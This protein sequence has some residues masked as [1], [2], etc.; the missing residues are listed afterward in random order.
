MPFGVG[1]GT[2]CLFR[3]ADDNWGEYNFGD[4]VT[5]TPEDWG[6][7]TDA[8]VPDGAKVGTLSSDAVFGLF[9]NPCRTE[10]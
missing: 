3:T 9:N 8:D 2:D 4:V 7:A 5:F 10:L 6:V 1:I